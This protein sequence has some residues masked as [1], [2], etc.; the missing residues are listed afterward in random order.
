ML[1]LFVSR[2]LD[3]LFT[4]LISEG[5]L[6]GPTLLCLLSDPWDEGRAQ[7]LFLE[8][9]QIVVILPTREKEQKGPQVV[10]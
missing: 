2:Y 9:E 5:K 8:G 1:L 10:L 4:A 3:K 6:E 7:R